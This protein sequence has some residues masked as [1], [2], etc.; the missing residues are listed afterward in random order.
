M[1]LDT[2]C[3]QT[4]RR[5]GRR[6][7]RALTK[8]VAALGS[9]FTLSYCLDPVAPDDASLLLTV[10]PSRVGVDSTASVRAVIFVATGDLLPYEA[11]VTF[12]VDGGSLCQ[13][14]DST[15]VGCGRPVEELPPAL[16][17]STHEGVG[18]VTFRSGSQPGT[19]TIVARS[20]SATDS[21]FITVGP[22]P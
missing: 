15:D 18:I 22:V 7:L 5:M 20:G 12:F 14:S 17:V 3:A 16:T 2:Q 8:I 21:A 13:G 4:P 11:N 6:P 9:V 19:V 1:S 10:E